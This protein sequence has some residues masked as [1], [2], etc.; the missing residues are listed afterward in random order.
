[1]NITRSA[2]VS[3]ALADLLAD[4][5]VALIGRVVD[6][7]PP[8]ATPAPSAEAASRARWLPGRPWP[9]S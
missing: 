9:F 7:P 4:Q 6:G 5:L 1:L 3:V 8:S 2:V